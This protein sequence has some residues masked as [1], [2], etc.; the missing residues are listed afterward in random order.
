[1]VIT[2]PVID[3]KREQLWVV[4]RDSRI[5]LYDISG[6]EQPRLLKQ[7]QLGE[8]KDSR[9][10]FTRA[11]TVV[12][13]DDGELIVTTCER[14]PDGKPE[15]DIHNRLFRLNASL[16]VVDKQNLGTMFTVPGSVTY[17]KSFDGDKLKYRASVPVPGLAYIP[18]YKVINTENKL[19]NPITY[20]FEDGH[21]DEWNVG[22]NA[23]IP[24]A[25]EMLRD[26]DR[27]MYY[28]T[29]NG[30]LK[31]QTPDYRQEKIFSTGA[32]KLGQYAA[33]YNDTILMVTKKELR[34]ECETCPG[35]FDTFL[36]ALNINQSEPAA[37][38]WQMP[39]SKFNADIHGGYFRNRP[40]MPVISQNGTL[41]VADQDYLT[42]IDVKNQRPLW[43]Y[44][45]PENA[46][47]NEV[48]LDPQGK[49]W[50]TQCLKQPSH[51]IADQETMV[52]SANCQI[53][54]LEGDG[55]TQVPGSLPE[56]GDLENTGRLYGSK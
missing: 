44:S 24:F 6:D 26:G 50:M 8:M 45:V 46:R 52:K 36:T 49:V 17:C 12:L 16:H 11:E 7:A 3:E 39:L 21:I 19:A 20:R 38:L 23:A 54:V 31:R 9:R 13:P 1:M 41:Y 10:D 43:R 34:N 22:S 18:R 27:T 42:A 30:E 37:P 35:H 32:S 28:I 55:T 25:S 33:L 2:A 14:H 47:P 5:Y 40:T 15:P 56:R 51:A 4:T 48:V 29:G 53:V